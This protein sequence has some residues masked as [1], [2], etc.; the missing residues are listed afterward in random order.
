MQQA[1]EQWQGKK[2]LILIAH[3]LST[4]RAADAIHV[5]AQGRVLESGDH[6]TLMRRDGAYAAMV[7]AQL[8]D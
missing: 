5:L 8:G 2:T 6:G 1:L 4:V 3:R 7:Q